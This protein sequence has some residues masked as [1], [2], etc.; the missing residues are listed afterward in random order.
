MLPFQYAKL[1]DQKYFMCVSSTQQS[2]QTHTLQLIDWIGLGE[3]LVKKLH[4]VWTPSWMYLYF[5][6]SFYCCTVSSVSSEYA[7]DSCSLMK[8]LSREAETNSV[9]VREDKYV[10]REAIKYHWIFIHDHTC[11]KPPCH[12][13]D[14][15]N[16]G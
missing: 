16:F 3:N 11:S 1:S 10:I 9:D 4:R 12:A 14:F 8:G 2:I 13:T 5:Y 6:W 7:I 15:V